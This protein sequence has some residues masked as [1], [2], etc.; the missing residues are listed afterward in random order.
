MAREVEVFPLAWLMHTSLL[1]A[2]GSACTTRWRWIVTGFVAGL[3]VSAQLTNVSLVGAVVATA[4]ATSGASAFIAVAIGGC[5]SWLPLNVLYLRHAHAQPHPFFSW[6]RPDG[7]VG[8]WLTHVTRA[9]YGVLS[10]ASVTDTTETWA[11]QARFYLDHAL[12]RCY[13]EDE[14]VGYAT[15]FLAALGVLVTCR[16]SVRSAT[17]LWLTV[18]AATVHAM[19][20]FSRANL[21]LDTG[22]LRGVTRRFLV[23]FDLYRWT[24]AHAGADWLAE[25]S[26]RSRLAGLVLAAA[27]VRLAIAAHRTDVPRDTLIEH[28][29]VQVLR[30]LPTNATLLVRG[31]LETN[32]VMFAQTVR[33]VRPDVA[34]VSVEQATFPWYKETQVPHFAGRL[35]WPERGDRYSPGDGFTMADLLQANA[36]VVAEHRCFLLGGWKEGD[37]TTDRYETT[38]SSSSP[39][40]LVVGGGSPTLPGLPVDAVMSL[41]DTRLPGCHGSPKMLHDESW[42]YQVHRSYFGAFAAAAADLLSS[43]MTVDAATPAYAALIDRATVLIDVA[44]TSSCAEPDITTLLNAGLIYERE[45]V[46]HN[47]QDRRSFD[48]GYDVW[49]RWVLRDPVTAAAPE[50]AAIR[51]WLSF[52]ESKFT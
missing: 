3:A 22:L 48:R 4:I 35:R 12:R 24:L 20:F 30:G 33:G 37:V 9:E 7:S 45:R 50:Y 40:R 49:R 34:L 32:A 44:L 8:E 52:Y 47:R 29:G 36:D 43:A 21:P 38:A 11:S 5:L 14:W 16:R 51:A 17:T 15:M 10:L 26:G 28:F 1:L 13:T 23:Q 2:A 6:G 46:L 41:V 31:D 19:L 27:A 42:D 18:G 25:R 39:A